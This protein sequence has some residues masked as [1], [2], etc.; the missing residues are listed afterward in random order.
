[1]TTQTLFV[2]ARSAEESFAEALRDLARDGIR[3]AAIQGMTAVEVNG[4]SR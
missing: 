1:M 2:R 3:A 4:S